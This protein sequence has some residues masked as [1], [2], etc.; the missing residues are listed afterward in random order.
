MRQASHKRKC[1]N[2]PRLLRSDFG[3]MS[4]SGKSQVPHPFSVRIV[5]FRPAL[6]QADLFVSSFVCRWGVP[7]FV[8]HAADSD[9]DKRY[10][11]RSFDETSSGTCYCSRVGRYDVRTAGFEESSYSVDLVGFA[12]RR[13]CTRRRKGRDYHE[14]PDSEN[15]HALFGYRYFTLL[16]A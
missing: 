15:R 13:Y 9:T 4:M 12:S 2:H 6:H 7:S 14:G 5:N 3:R 16:G 8:R 11:I 1:Q 10:P